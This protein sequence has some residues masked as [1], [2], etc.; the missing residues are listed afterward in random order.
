MNKKKLHMACKCRLFNEWQSEL[1]KE[2]NDLPKEEALNGQLAQ[3]GEAMLVD[4]YKAVKKHLWKKLEEHMKDERKLAKFA[5]SQKNLKRD[6]EKGKAP[7][8]TTGGRG[9][10]YQSRWSSYP[11]HK[12]GYQGAR[13]A[14]YMQG[15]GRGSWGGDRP[16]PYPIPPR[17]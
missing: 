7:Q 9:S 17:R 6:K 12:W 5:N 8:S 13:D 2:Q 4:V 16:R 3:A 1:I 15:R 10:P 11:E 14:P